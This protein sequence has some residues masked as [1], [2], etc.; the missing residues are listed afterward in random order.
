MSLAIPRY[1]I[2]FTDDPDAVHDVTV[3]PVDQMR[4]EVEGNR[5]GLVDPSRQAVL[6]TMLWLWAAARRLDLVGKDQA[7]DPFVN[8]LLAWERVKPQD[9]SEVQTVDPTQPGGSSNDSSS[10]RPGS[11]AST[12]SQPSS[13]TLDSSPR[14]D[15]SSDGTT[16]TTDGGLS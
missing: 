2:T 16:T 4:A 5:R 1:R 7:F 11:P 14:P 12:G 13:A 6:L 8:S 10:S 9:G 15:D 3:L